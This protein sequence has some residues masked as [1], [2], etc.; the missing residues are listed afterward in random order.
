MVGRSR[1]R[2]SGGRAGISISPTEL[3]A[4]DLRARNSPDSV[5]RA[6]IDA[7]SL[8]DGNWP[9]LVSALAGLRTHFGIA[10]GGTLAVSLM[11]PFTEARR[12]ELPPLRDEDLHRALSRGAARYFVGAKGPQVVGASLAGRRVRRAPT[13]VIA[14][15][16]PTR[17]IGAIRTAAR[18][19]GWTIDIIAPPEG[20]WAS[21]ALAAWPKF[22]KQTAH[23]IIAQDD[24]TDVLTI[25]AG[26][27]A[28]V[29]RFRPGASDAAMIAEAVGSSARV[30]LFGLPSAR[31]LLATSLSG[32]GIVAAPLPDEWRGGADHADAIAARF[33]GGEMGP[34]L[35]GEDAVALERGKL[36]TAAWRVAGAAAAMFVAAAGI[37]SWGVHRQLKNVREE[38]TLLRPRIASTMVGRTTVDAAYRHLSTLSALERASP[39]WSGVIGTLTDAIPQDAFLL[40]IRTR[41]D[42]IIVDGL[43]ERARRVF[44]SMEK[45]RG[46]VDVRAAAPVRRELQEG[47]TEAL[48]HFV[49]AS[50]VARPGPPPV[51]VPASNPG[52]RQGGASK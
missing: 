25:D 37:Q 12:L 47:G 2:G 48:E 20:A 30:G 10:G 11:P 19:A 27:L 5:W 29:R 42:S 31:R 13:A 46:L 43:A 39:R 35:R 8:E 24:R 23:V 32:F 52:P 22:S 6:P 49:I 21:A 36:R 7:P 4:A 33:A 9:S 51:A 1:S 40:A 50:R 38:R 18:Q 17:L 41:D 16:A 45:A 3:C 28:G 26:R 15:A 44:D 34:V 14:A